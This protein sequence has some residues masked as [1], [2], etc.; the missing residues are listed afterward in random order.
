[1][2]RKT[3]ILVLFLAALV[4]APGAQSDKLDY[5]AIG[6]IRDEGLTRS[7]VMDTLFWLTDRYGPRLTGTPAIDEAGEWT[8]KTMTAWGLSNVHREEWDFGRGW[9]LVRFSAHIVEPRIQPLIGFPKSWS[10]GTDGP[11]S[12]DV[13]RA[14]FATDADFAKYKGQLKGK[15]VLSQPSRAVRMLEGPFI[16]K[17]DG[18]LAK[19]AETTPIPAQRGRGGR[20]GRGAAPGA[21]A[22][23]D[24]AGDAST[25]A[26]AGQPGQAA[27]QFQQ[28]LQQFYKEEGVVAVFDRGSDADTANMGSGLSVNQQHP[29]GGTVFPGSVD[30]S[31]AAGVPQV[32]LAVEHY[33]RMVR[34]LEH[35]VPVKAELD[36][37]VQF[38]ENAK[39]FNIVGEI[40]GSDPAGE[41]VML[42][43]HFDSHP[44]ATGAT[45][46][47]TGTTAM[48]EAL[49][50]IKTLGLKPRRTIR[51][52][53]WGGEEQ[54]LLGSKA[55]VLAH[56]ADPQ[57][58][59]VKPEHAK[60]S[61]YF[62]L[63]NGT[64]RIR[65]IWMQGNLAARPIFEQWIEPLK[66][67]GVTILGPRSVAQTDQ[68]SF[69]AVGLPGFQFVQ[70][71]LEY[72][73]RTHHSNM[74]VYDRAQRDEL[75]QQATVAAV[76]AYDAAMRTEKMPRKAL[77]K[78][79]RPAAA[80]DER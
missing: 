12:A 22:A 21:D 6:Q 15:I 57:T 61:A 33:N 14:T 60:L 24:P 72:N 80:T 54:G 20:G 1:M 39:G 34:L 27:Q 71:R 41:V 53:L 79:Q 78:P 38:H 32:T 51:V 29:D 70:D 36:L 50:I 25:A 3:S 37:R 63:D 66:D 74:D 35:N 69:D 7:Q 44:F 10:V 62:N 18:D 26:G 73:S 19:E 76:F 23:A 59:Q 4:A 47:A 45:D 5:A 13:L 58:M 75:V 2:I 68:S 77:P 42:G 56:F 28:R 40:P 55:Y 31:A 9:S 8:M 67:L 65:G 46:N 16:V 64:G 30:R 43:A 49:R 17:M 48:L 52:A 11:V